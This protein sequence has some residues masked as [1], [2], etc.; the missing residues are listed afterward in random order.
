M[1]ITDFNE[2]IVKFGLDFEVVKTPLYSVFDGVTEELPDSY[3]SLK[4]ADTNKT[5][6]V[7]S[8][9]Y[10]IL[11]P[12]E[13]FKGLEFLS[14]TG[15]VEWIN[16]GTFGTNNGSIFLQAKLKNDLQKLARL[17]EVVEARINFISSYNKKVANVITYQALKKVCENGLIVPD[18]SFETKI[19]NVGEL[20]DKLE[21]LQITLE[22]FVRDFSRIDTILERFYKTK[23]NS[24]ASV[25][26]FVELVI[27]PSQEIS[28]DSVLTRLENR[29]TEAYDAIYDSVGQKDLKMTLYKLYSG[30]SYLANHT[31]KEDNFQYTNFGT[32]AKLMRV[33]YQVCK[34][35]LTNKSILDWMKF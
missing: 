29:R 26:R 11:S 24:E 19:R 27:T 32:G 8:S 16:G 31:E 7:V 23:I 13:K 35:Y 20:F 22:G 21:D 9:R 6:G 33:A 12:R 3:Q 28:E 15:S 1:I 34:E 2:A 5:L 30:I 10:P 18:V 25:K 17:G 4:R 14:R